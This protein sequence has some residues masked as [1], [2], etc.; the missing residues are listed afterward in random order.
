[1]HK[2]IFN[3]IGLEI[4]K[5]DGDS[6]GDQSNRL[7]VSESRNN[8]M[9]GFELIQKIFER[10]SLQDWSKVQRSLGNKLHYQK[11][12]LLDLDINAKISDVIQAINYSNLNLVVLTSN[13]K[14]QVQGMIDIH[15]IITF[16]VNN[17]K[18]EISFFKHY[19]S[20]FESKSE[21]AHCSKN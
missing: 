1:M 3:A 15:D 18:G 8:Q 21:I 2:Y 4:S 9:R 11:Q 7:Q 19:F 16:L 13:E 20:K 6:N 14:S 5:D 10:I 12:E 17:Y